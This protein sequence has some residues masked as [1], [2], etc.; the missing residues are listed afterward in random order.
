MLL[1][2]AKVINLTI[3]VALGTIKAAQ[4]SRTIK[5]EKAIH[6]LIDYWA[7]HPDATLQYNANGMI[8]K[9]HSNV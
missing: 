2:Y 4:T 8:L 1:F 5:T 6:K 3:L 9:T 7:T